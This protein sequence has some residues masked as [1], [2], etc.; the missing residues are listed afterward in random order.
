MSA[1][2]KKD[3]RKNGQRGSTK[4]NQG[5][6]PWSQQQRQEKNRGEKKRT[7]ELKIAPMMAHEVKRNRK[8]KDSTEKET[9]KKKRKK[10]KKPPGQVKPPGRTNIFE[11]FGKKK[12]LKREQKGAALLEPS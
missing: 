8:S 7:G 3:P 12:N 6:L 4:S 2:E 10:D 11:E 1:G 9:L 5:T